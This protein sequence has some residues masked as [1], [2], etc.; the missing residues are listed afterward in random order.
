MTELVRVRRGDAGLA[1][2]AGPGRGAWLCREH[3]VECLD[4][5][6]R[7]R[8][9]ALALREPVTSNDLLGVRATLEAS[10]R[11]PARRSSEPWPER[12][13]N[14]AA[15]SGKRESELAGGPVA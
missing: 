13:G 3:A 9:L 4:R 7:G 10:A 15:E 6:E 2:G 5:A 1:L 14:E 11:E 8:K 12:P